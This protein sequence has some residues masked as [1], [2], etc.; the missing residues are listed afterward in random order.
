VQKPNGEWSLIADY[1]GLNEITLPLSV[2]V[3]DMLERQLELESKAAKWYA[4]SE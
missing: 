4:T 2:A 3:P 1:R